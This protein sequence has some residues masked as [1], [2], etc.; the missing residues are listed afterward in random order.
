MIFCIYYLVVLLLRRV[1]HPQPDPH[2]YLVSFLNMMHIPCVSHVDAQV[3]PDLVNGSTSVLLTYL[4]SFGGHF[5]AFWRNEM[6]KAHRV[7]FLPCF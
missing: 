4:Y 5:L 3:V 2:P 7:I 6:F 1:L